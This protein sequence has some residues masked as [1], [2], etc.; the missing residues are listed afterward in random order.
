MAATAPKMSASGLEPRT[1][2][3]LVDSGGPP[4]E[5]AVLVESAPVSAPVLESVGLEI[6][7]LAPG[8][9]ETETE[10]EAEV[11]VVMSVVVLSAVVLTS[12]ED[13]V[14]EAL[15]ADGVEEP[16]DSEELP[17]RAIRPLKLGSA[18]SWAISSA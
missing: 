17:L 7:L 4:V 18:P 8:V 15:V 5:V 12:V 6:V 14:S 9:D 10:A 1:V 2:A 11:A 13:M 3:A 16:D